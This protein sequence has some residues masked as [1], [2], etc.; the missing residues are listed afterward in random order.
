[1]S[2]PLALGLAS[3]VVELVNNAIGLLKE[4]KEAAKRSKD[5][6]LK[7]KLGEVFDAV[8]ELKDAIGNLRAE[9]ADCENNWTPEQS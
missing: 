3:T 5:H 4:A 1:M 2:D 7:E 9:N 6:D 8:L